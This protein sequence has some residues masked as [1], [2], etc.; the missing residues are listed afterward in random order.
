VQLPEALRD[1]VNGFDA[2]DYP[3]LVDPATRSDGVGV[4]AGV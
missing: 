3:E 1:F 2:G 4:L